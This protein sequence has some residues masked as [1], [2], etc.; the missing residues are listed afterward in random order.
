LEVDEAVA[1]EQPAGLISVLLDRDA[2]EDE[3]DDAAGDL[4]GYDGDE[5]IAALAH[6]ASSPDEHDDTLLDTCGES[7][8]G[9]WARTGMVQP[10]VYRALRK[11]ARRMVFVIIEHRAPQLLPRLGSEPH[12]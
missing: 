10:E 9:I 2:R 3:R 5:V 7:L 6:V 1:V 4:E 12:R 8:G 11:P